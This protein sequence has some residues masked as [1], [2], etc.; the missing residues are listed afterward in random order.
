MIEPALPVE[1]VP[2]PPHR[3]RVVVANWRDGGHPDAGGAEVYAER[4]A[5][6]LAAAGHQVTFLAA[7]YEPS[8]GS[9]ASAWT[10][11]TGEARVD[12]VRG[13][14]R[15]TVYPWVAWWLVR[16][17]RE[18]DVVIDCQNGI[19]FFAPLWVRR[20]TAVLCVV[21]HV[22]TEQFGLHFPAPVA[23]VGRLLEGPATRRVYGHRPAIAVSPSTAR[24]LRHRLRWRG[25]IHVVPNGAPRPH[26]P[27][28]DRLRT[29]MPT[30]VSVG[31]LVVHKRV[32]LLIE[33]AGRLRPKR[34][35]LRVDVIGSGPELPA[36][37]SLAQAEC[38]G[39]SLVLHGRLDDA[40]VERALDR[41]WL[42][43]AT[44]RG[45]GW[46][47]SV[48]EA[49]ARGVPT[50]AFCVDGLSDAIR[51]GRTGWLVEDG[52]DL[53]AAIDEALQVLADPAV[54]RDMAA[55]CRAWAAEFSW[56]AS[57]LRLRAVM[58][59]EVVS[60]SGR[61]RERRSVVDEAVLVELGPSAADRV[62]AIAGSLRSTDRFGVWEARPWL[63]LTG[64]PLDMA[65]PVLARLHLGHAL[66]E[67]MPRVATTE[68]LLRA[69]PL[70]GDVEWR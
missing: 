28:T 54:A 12:H 63:L 46:G 38:P 17:R 18:V 1:P 16:R 36:L 27:G 40:D 68:D 47:L 29:P 10:S 34:P 56:A 20:R 70:R 8:K 60:R 13:G 49:A 65:A 64:C 25:P 69:E 30:V 66:R 22:H 62:E 14:G 55:Q 4:L 6:E 5:L 67:G 9:E 33:A 59:S 2:A 23:A 37:R 39:D 42:A 44:T 41:S 57:G 19:P 53:A 3:L 26:D 48:L 24:A 32:A 52:R 50:V 31:R 58:E 45:E 15:W 43:V 21:H 51:P 35:D 7:S 11:E 61:A